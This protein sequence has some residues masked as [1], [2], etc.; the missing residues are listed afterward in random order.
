[1]ANWFWIRPL[2]N[3]VP[4]S[5]S[6]VVVPIRL[7]TMSYI[8]PSVGSFIQGAFKMHEYRFSKHLNRLENTLIAID[9]EIT[10]GSELSLGAQSLD[11][12]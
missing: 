1:M 3:I 5:R 7:C 10:E 4:P 6:N 8:T 9:P 12:Y 2:F 11:K